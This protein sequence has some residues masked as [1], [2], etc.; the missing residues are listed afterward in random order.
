[1][2]QATASSP[3]LPQYACYLQKIPN[4]KMLP[5]SSGVTLMNRKEIYLAPFP[6]VQAQVCSLIELPISG[7]LTEQTLNTCVANSLKK[8]AG[9]KNHSQLEPLL[10]TKARKYFGTYYKSS[11]MA[12]S[13]R[14]PN[15]KRQPH[16]STRRIKDNDERK[17]QQVVANGATS[18]ENA[19]LK[20]G[21][22]TLTIGLGS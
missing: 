5:S 7:N 9:K 10:I 6:I 22:D 12:T 14:R 15:A 17:L 3:S 19:H 20:T 4:L 11:R 13:K 2:D 21:R 18:S 1:M 16:E 8:L